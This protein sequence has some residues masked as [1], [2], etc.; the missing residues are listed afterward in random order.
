MSC[1]IHTSK[2]NTHHPKLIYLFSNCSLG[3]DD[4]KSLIQEAVKEEIYLHDTRRNPET[5]KVFTGDQEPSRTQTAGSAGDCDQS[6][7]QLS[8]LQELKVL[9]S[10]DEK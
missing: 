5:D 9:Q 3:R 8:S 7:S 1:L 6:A 4:L 2:Q 10:V